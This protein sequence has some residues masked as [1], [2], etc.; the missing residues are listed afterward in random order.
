M[1]ISTN[2]LFNIVEIYLLMIMKTK[3][4]LGVSTLLLVASGVIGILSV[5]GVITLPF[6]II[7]E[8]D[9]NFEGDHQ[10]P[11]YVGSIAVDENYDGDL[12]A[13]ADISQIQAEQIALDYTTGG[14]IVSSFL[15]NENGYLVWKIVLLY[16]NAYYEIIVDAGNGQVLWASVEDTD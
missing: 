12:L 9:G 16:D 8:E 5:T 15:E 7:P 4:I 14:I 13:F 2:N 3:Y 11:D 6:T 10:F 1:K